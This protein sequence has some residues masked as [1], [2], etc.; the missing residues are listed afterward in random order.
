MFENLRARILKWARALKAEIAVLA[1]AIRDPRTP[2][3]AKALGMFIVGYAVSPIDLI[4][5]FIPVLGFVDDALLLPLGIWAVRRMIPA[6][7]MAE[8]RAKVEAG[9]RLPPNRTAAAIIIGL[10][11][12]GSAVS[13]WWLWNRFVR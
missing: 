3:Y 2:W 11:I 12:V 8:H 1:A 7:V 5:D 6:E 13:A 9:T 10:W 4:P